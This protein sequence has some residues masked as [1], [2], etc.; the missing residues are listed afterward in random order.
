MVQAVASQFLD[1]EVTGFALCIALRT[2][3]MNEQ[4]AGPGTGIVDDSA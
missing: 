3:S 2:M 1:G 4:P